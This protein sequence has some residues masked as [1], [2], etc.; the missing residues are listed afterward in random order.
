MSSPPTFRKVDPAGLPVLAMALMSDIE[1]L[2][3]V[4]DNA[5]TILVSAETL[6][7]VSLVTIGGMQKPSIRVQVIS[8][9]A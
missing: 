5:D 9:N 3:K 6:T 7:G 2:T 1:P 4:D 8:P